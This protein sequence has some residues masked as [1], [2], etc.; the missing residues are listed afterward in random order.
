M[1][2]KYWRKT[3]NILFAF[4][5]L[6]SLLVPLNINTTKAEEVITVADAIANNSGN[7]TVEGYIVGVTETGPSYKH[8]SPF[9]VN[10]NL[11]IADDPT[12][13]DPTK[14]MPVQLPN[15][16]IR[17]NLN[18]KDNEVN[19]GKK[20]QM[21]GSLELYFGAPGLKS[22]TSYTF[23]HETNPLKVQVVTG[24]PVSGAV[25]AGTELELSTE[26]SGATIYY[27]TDGSEPT[28]QSTPYSAPIIITEDMTIKAIATASGLENS[29]VASFEYTILQEKTIADARI[30]PNKTTAMVSGTVTGIFTA[31]GKNNVFIQDETAGIIVR[32][33]ALES[34]I[35]VGDGIQVSGSINDYY[36]MPQLEVTD[37]SSVSVIQENAGVPSAQLITSLDLKEDVEGELVTIKSVTV[38]TKDHNGNYSSSD[39]NGNFVI[40]PADGSLL[41]SGKTYA[42]ITGV[43][44]Y[45]FS[46]YKL[47]PRHAGDVIEDDTKVGAVAANPAAGF[48]KAGDTVSLT[49]ATE[50]A[51]IYYTT[52]NTEPST[53]GQVYSQPI[54]ITKDTTIK[55]IAVKENLT[56][57]DIA[58]F[59]YM[60]QKD[61]I[62]IHDIQGTGHFS[63]FKDKT[64]SGIEGIVTHILDSK[65][66]YMQDLQPDSD[67]QTSEGILVY[68]S[69]PGVSVGDVVKVDGTVKEWVLEGYSEKLETDLP[70]TE[71]NAASITKVSS[72]QPLPEPI[73]IG[74]DRHLPTEIIDNDVF[75]EFDPE[76]DGIDFFES[77]EGMLVGVENPKVVAPQ[78]YGELVVVPGNVSTNT[79]NGGLRITGTDF[80]PERIHIDINDESYKAKAGDSFNGLITGVVSYGFSNY[81]VLSNKEN[82]PVFVEGPTTQEITAISEHPDKLTIA[83]YNVENFSAATSNEKV[84]KLAEAIVTNLQK[85]DIIGI[86]EM[87]DNDGPADSGVTDA[88]ESAAKLIEKIKELGGP[89]Y[90]Y[91]D[92]APEHKKDGGQPGGN[93]RGGFLY[94]KDRVSLTE[95][96][97]GTAAQ[98]VGFENGK[99]TLNPGRIDPTNEAFNS[100]RKPLAA[101]FE[102]NGK[103]IIVVA[104]HFNSKGGDQPLFGKNQPPVLKSEEQRHKIAQIVNNFVKD[105]KEQ[106]P[107]ANIVVLGDLNDFEF[108]K[109][110]DIL[111]GSELANMIEQ[112]PAEE[113]FSY[114]YQGNSQVLD[115]ILVSK[116]LEL[117]TKVDIVH[118]NSSFMEVHGRASDHDPVL[119]QLSLQDGTADPEE[120]TVANLRDFKTKKLVIQSVNK[121]FDIDA[122]TVISDHIL[123]KTSAA[124]RGEGLKHIVFKLNPSAPGAVIDFTGTEVKEILVE[125]ENV[126]QVK[127]I[128]DASVVKFADGVDPSKVEIVIEE[129]AMLSAS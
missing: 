102:F 42:S 31:G 101:Q 1:N 88:S 57:S 48:V 26:T 77:L 19:L 51:V 86:T 44:E 54:T 116:N 58:E 113:R 90:L 122:E 63:P 50:G 111:K 80:N 7:A 110:L 61:D 96:I 29:D 68:K 103:S 41:E 47:V 59:S 97:K 12:E 82:L 65:N 56:N 38:G 114:T 112:V 66:F 95:G 99:L 43:V 2:R 94:N 85:P 74:K 125:N 40:K 123:V 98:S 73:I 83:S 35:S 30:L 36:G 129:G 100:S 28:E 117:S 104:N 70:V 33:T 115:H 20:I 93:I 87:Q 5:L 22:P 27:T 25:A 69:S 118:I 55:A 106:D 11:A 79:I 128:Q 45:N 17:T 72:A 14:I 91:T 75:A 120:S 78:K 10:T 16:S 60:I 84:T 62:R 8:Q 81:K 21:T 119:V 105:V 34:K 92:I 39:T 6:F 127:G 15:N 23:V 32:G 9:T 107:D 13:K 124:F 67:D 89:D 76:E 4:T 121:L 53:A 52:D 109:T 18:L 64:V 46:E 108:S 37:L 126:K 3:F 71:I 49:T 24:N